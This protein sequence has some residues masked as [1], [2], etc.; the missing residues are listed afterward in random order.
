MHLVCFII[1]IYH[2]ARLPECQIKGYRDVQTVVTLWLVTELMDRY[3]PEGTE[4][5]AYYARNINARNVGRQ[6]E[7]LGGVA[8]KLNVNREQKLHA[9]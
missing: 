7:K 9:L 2:D 8:V 3:Q 6:C 1:R 5:L 4:N